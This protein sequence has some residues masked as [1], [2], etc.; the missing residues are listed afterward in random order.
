M[1]DLITMHW[2]SQFPSVAHT[3]W[4]ERE[5]GLSGLWGLTVSWLGWTW[6]NTEDSSSEV[7]STFTW[8]AHVL[9]W[10]AGM[11][12]SSSFSDFRVTT[13]SFRLQ[14]FSSSCWSPVSTWR[15]SIWS[16]PPPP[17]SCLP[18]QAWRCYLCWLCTWPRWAHTPTWP[19][20]RHHCS[21]QEWPQWWSR[22][23]TVSIQN[24]LAPAS[25]C[26]AGWRAGGAGYLGGVSLSSSPPPLCHLQP[27]QSQE[28]N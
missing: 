21:S 22:C 11:Y 15:V 23:P 9:L 2:L 17:S 25:E 4:R 18:C 28:P 7:G 14:F 26:R 5:P 16:S 8:R 12:C 10:A 13:Y 3:D 1:E 20:W 19:G 6:T 27:Q 24:S